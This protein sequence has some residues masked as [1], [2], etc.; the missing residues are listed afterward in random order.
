MNHFVDLVQ[1][2]PLIAL[3][4]ASALFALIVGAVL[5]SGRKGNFS[6]RTLGWAFV[7]AMGTAALSSAFI[8]DASLPNIAGFTP[9]HLLTLSVLVLLPMGIW[10]IRSGNV[11]AH[12]RTM[13]GVFVGGC[14]VAGLFTLLP[15]RFLG[16][17]LWKQALGL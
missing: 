13:S 10:R 14:I 5:M 15:G 16:D 12:R 17:L 3:H 2:R 4:L 1:T 7:A 11:R 9:I 6:H 8:R